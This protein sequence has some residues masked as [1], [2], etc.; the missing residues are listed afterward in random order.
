MRLLRV[1]ID[2]SNVEVVSMHCSAIVF[3]LLLHLSLQVIEIAHDS[4]FLLVISLLRILFFH[5]QIC[6][7]FKGILIFVISDLSHEFFVDRIETELKITVFHYFLQDRVLYHRSCKDLSLQLLLI[8][9]VDFQADRVTLCLATINT[10]KSYLEHIALEVLL[11][12]KS[13]LNETI[14]LIISIYIL[15]PSI[16]PS[17]FCL[18][19]IASFFFVFGILLFLILLASFTTRLTRL[20]LFFLLFVLPRG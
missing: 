15:S 13:S 5:K 20:A 11:L 17:S 12:I 1:F 6:L 16:A 8:L 10:G 3:F 2:L 19:R 7:I 14:Y 18:L 4:P 9:I